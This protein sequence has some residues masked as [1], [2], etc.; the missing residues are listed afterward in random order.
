MLQIINSDYAFC[1]LGAITI[2]AICCYYWHIANFFIYFL[3]GN[4]TE[5]FTDCTISIHQKVM[6]QSNPWFSD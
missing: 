4:N 2:T 6:T 1:N 3:L 5:F